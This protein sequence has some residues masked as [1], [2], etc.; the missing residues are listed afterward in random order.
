VWKSYLQ[1]ETALSTSTEAEY[2]ALSTALREVISLM[3]LL[4]E[5]QLHSIPNVTV[6]PKIYCKVFEDNSGA[7]AMAQVPTMRPHTKHLNVKYHH[8]CDHVARGD[9][10][11]FP[12]ASSA[13]Q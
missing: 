12:V 13:D 9:I 4:K 8:F 3:S 7:F 5:T 1:T 2:I 6:T 10:S 11:I